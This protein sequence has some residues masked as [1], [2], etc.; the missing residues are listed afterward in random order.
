MFQAFMDE[1]LHVPSL[2]N[3]S[4]NGSAI[5]PKTLCPGLQLSLAVNIQKQ[6]KIC[7]ALQKCQQGLAL[8]LPLGLS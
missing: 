8:L 5:W 6:F 2:E 3:C 7:R 4:P 1:V